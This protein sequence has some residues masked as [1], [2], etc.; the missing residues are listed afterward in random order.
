MAMGAAVLAALFPRRMDAPVTHPQDRT[1][2]SYA[3]TAPTG[4][5]F[6]PLYQ[7]QMVHIRIQYNS[8]GVFS[9]FEEY[10]CLRTDM[11]FAIRLPGSKHPLKKNQQYFSEASNENCTTEDITDP[12]YLTD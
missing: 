11:C 4:H 7:Q 9:D 10:G 3:P 2:Q 8:V 12:A 1:G 6:Q 5:L